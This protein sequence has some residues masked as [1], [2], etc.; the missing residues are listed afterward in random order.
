MR[1][2]RTLPVWPQLRRLIIFQLKL[3]IDAFRDFFLSLLS[4]VAFVLDVITNN[5]G[6]GS[7]FE[8]VLKLGRRTERAINLFD[9]YSGSEAQGGKRV[10][11]FIDEV[12]ERFRQRNR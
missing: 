2:K 5:H 3:Y 4:F 1:G 9:Q 11:D 6:P 7:H 8:N 10:D 12:E